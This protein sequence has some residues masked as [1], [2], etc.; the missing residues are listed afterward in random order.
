[1]V[2]GQDQ[3]QTQTHCQRRT[4]QR[5]KDALQTAGCVWRDKS[6][7]GC[8]QLFV[9]SVCSAFMFRIITQICLIVSKW[10]EHESSHKYPYTHTIY[11]TTY[12]HYT[13]YCKHGVEGWKRCG[14]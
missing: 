4:S 7:L 14:V 1:M 11:Q 10:M 3:R 12:A 5:I 2:G 6:T 13:V 9:C 8:F